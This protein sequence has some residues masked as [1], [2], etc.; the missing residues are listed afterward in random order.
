MITN[1][2]CMNTARTGVFL[3]RGFAMA[4]KTTSAR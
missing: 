4:V 1:Q 3:V 2:I